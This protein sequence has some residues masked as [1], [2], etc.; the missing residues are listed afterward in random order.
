MLGSLG[1]LEASRQ[2][3]VPQFLF[4]SSVSVYHQV[5]QDRP[6][7]ERHPTWPSTI[8]GAAKAAVESHLIAYRHTY[9]MNASAWRP[10]AVYGIPPDPR[11]AQW[12]ELILRRETR[13]HG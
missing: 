1:L 13:R 5:L 2:A 12:G 7:D 9:G 4:V 8:Y 11:Y 6:L 3:G 10:A